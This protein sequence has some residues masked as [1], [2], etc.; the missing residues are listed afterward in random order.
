MP[1]YKTTQKFRLSDGFAI[2]HIGEE[3]I[4]VPISSSTAD[5]GR[6]TTLNGTGACILNSLTQGRDIGGA[7]DD[8]MERYAV[9]DRRTVEND[10]RSFI[11][12]MVSCGA[13]VASDDTSC[14]EPNIL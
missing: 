12:K 13:L 7:V 3:I 5:M 9:A 10:V 11:A 14:H 4:I 6:L 8:I 2:S 1:E